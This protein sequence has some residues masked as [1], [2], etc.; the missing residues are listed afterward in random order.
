MITSFRKQRRTGSRLLPWRKENTLSH[1]GKMLPEQQFR[2]E[3]EK[4]LSRVERRIELTQFALVLLSTDSADDTM[5]DEFAK[6]LRIT[7]SIG[8]CE[9][10]LGVLLPETDRK[11]AQFVADDL[12]IIGRKFEL[13]LNPDVLIFPDDDV[14][15]S[16]SSEIEAEDFDDKHWEDRNGHQPPAPGREFSTEVEE[17]VVDEIGTCDSTTTAFTASLKTPIWKRALDVFGS[18]FG[19]LALSPIFLIAG[20]V[21]WA[22]SPGPIFFRQLREGKDGKKFY[23][24]KF[25]TMCNDAEALK[26]SL[27]HRSEQDGPAFKLAH[28]PRLTAV[29]KYLR[30]SCIDELPQ[31]INVL[32]GDM[33]LVGPRPLPVDE[34]TECEV[35]QRRRLMILPGIT[36]VWQARGDRNIKF[37]DWMRMDMEYLRKRSFLFD[38][39]LI[40]E[41]IF[42]VVLH[43]GS[44]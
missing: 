17:L 27:R 22:T 2:F 4:E 41:T 19:L 36:C 28:D 32:V 12:E 7:D 6:R 15:A 5:I 23:I 39:K 18:A 21:I 33:S 11:G 14:I 9:N 37:S 34:S 1:N 20:I 31:L 35:W 13:N 8:W 42:S 3:L 16:N 24:Y 30:R 43:R 10:R 38:M 26:K 29:G 44:V 40:G 25:R